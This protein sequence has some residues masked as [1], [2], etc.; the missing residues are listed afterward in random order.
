M[1]TTRSAIVR[2]RNTTGRRR[3]GAVLSLL[4]VLGVVL[5]PG[6]AAPV[7]TPALVPAAWGAEPSPPAPTPAGPTPAA[8]PTPTGPTPTDPCPVGSEETPVR[9]DVTTLAPRAPSGPDEPFQVAGRLTNC[10]RQPLDR[11]QVRLAVG[12]KIDSRSGLAR[13][14][15]EPVLGS[16]RLTATPAA[17]ESLAPG[18]STS[19]DLRLLVRDL[20]LGRENGVFPLAVQ[21]RAVYGSA[22][23]RESVGLASTFV[24]WFPDGPIAPTRLAWLVPLV[25]QPRADP[26]GVLLDDALE[27]LL[28]SDPA[29]PGRLS[30]VLEAAR[31][32]AMGAC[33]PPAAPAGTPPAADPG[34]ASTAP[35][36][37]D[38]APT[39]PQPPAGCRGEA[40]PVT[41]GVEPDLLGTVETMTR[42]HPVLERGKPVQRPASEAAASWLMRVRAAAAVGSVLALPY[43]DPDVVALSRTESGV[44]DDVGLLRRLGQSEARRLLGVEELLT[45]ISWPPPGPIGGALDALAA[46]GQGADPPT[47]VLGDE[48]LPEVPERVGRTPSARTTLSS[49]TGPVTALTVDAGLSL[50]T[51]AN[52]SDPSWQ[53]ARLAEQR[54]IA[55]AAVIAAERPGESRT[56]LV[57]PRRHADLRS[58]VAGAVIAD[59]GRLPWLCPVSLASAAAGTERC[60]QLPD[61]QG[62][63]KAEARGAPGRADRG[64]AALP[65]AFVEQLS[66]VRRRSDQFTDEVLLAG[67]EQAK[68]TKA[69]LLRARGRAAS[70]AWRDDQAQGRRLLG[71]LREE[72]DGLRGQVRLVSGPVLLTGSTGTMR[73]TVENTLNQPVSIG[74]RLDDTTEARLSSSDTA[75]REVPGNQAIQLAVQVE[76][77]TSG[78]FIARARLIDGSGDFFGP[79]VDLAVRSTQYGRVALGIT[80]VA[81]AVLLVAAGVRITRR[82][83]HRPAGTRS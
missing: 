23:N 82:A 26:D 69:A 60:A 57:A 14:T 63:A 2:S 83:L 34:T 4:T 21:A 19:F 78:R 55:E 74:V 66:E 80:G 32:G 48:L 9:V 52:P 5:A 17:D 68:T 6:V 8:A 51:E 70:S 25:D 62:P 67:S 31:G 24:P 72:V 65:V 40:V 28:S 56:F 18:E 10:G 7:L 76:V 16:R 47:V 41:Y 12:G 29:R 64:A 49:T 27:G 53:G 20:G 81:A 3:P 59:T 71:L 43:G 38:P 61:A 44:R 11:L 54:W 73:L 46:G 58:G 39:T 37:P 75:V 50:L 1:G 15:A 77:Q 45:S 35:P 42:P 36:T 79:P 22:A 33:D 30:R 13:A